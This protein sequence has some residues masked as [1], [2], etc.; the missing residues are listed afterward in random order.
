M[1]TSR[2]KHYSASI[3]GYNTLIPHV[4]YAD[5]NK[6]DSLSDEKRNPN[7]EK[8]HKESSNKDDY[9]KSTDQHSLNLLTMTKSMTIKH[10][11]EPPDRT[12][13]NKDTTLAEIVHSLN[14]SNF[15]RAKDFHPRTTDTVLN[16]ILNQTGTAVMAQ[17]RSLARNLVELFG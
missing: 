3:L 1:R 17:T 15:R 14:S 16:Q 12:P 10:Y 8:H 2:S 13:S 5:A 9:A 6:Q 11:F 4:P 7:N